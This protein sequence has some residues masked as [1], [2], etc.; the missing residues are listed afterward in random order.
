VW[1][2]LDCVHPVAIADLTG[3]GRSVIYDLCLMVEHARLMRAPRRGG[4]F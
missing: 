2:Q 3:A 4:G 1:F